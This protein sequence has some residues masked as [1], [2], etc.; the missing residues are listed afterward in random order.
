[1]NILVNGVRRPDWSLNG[2]AE[3]LIVIS[4]THSLLLKKNVRQTPF[5]GRTP[6]FLPFEGGGQIFIC[7]IF[8]YQSWGSRLGLVLRVE[9]TEE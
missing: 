2:S 9:K 7:G 8:A 6:K 1:M 4:R 5:I 3:W